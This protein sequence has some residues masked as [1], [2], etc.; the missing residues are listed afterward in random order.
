VQEVAIL[1]PPVRDEV[2]YANELAAWFTLG[3]DGSTISVPPGKHVLMRGSQGNIVVMGDTLAQ[4]V[5]LAKRVE[6]AFAGE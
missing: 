5:A 3:N 6:R 2:R 4:A 1:K